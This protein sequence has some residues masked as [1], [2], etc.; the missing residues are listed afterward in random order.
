M[1]SIL[2]FSDDHY[3]YQHAR[4]L[5][6]FFSIHQALYLRKP[7]ERFVD[8]DFEY[9]HLHLIVDGGALSCRFTALQ[10]LGSIQE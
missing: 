10:S 2:Q 4:P 8:D 1:L 7:I 6:L 9:V 3:S 5:E